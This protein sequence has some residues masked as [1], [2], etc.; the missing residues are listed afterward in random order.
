M[1]RYYKSGGK[2]CPKGKA[3]AN[4]PLTHIL[5]RMLI[6]LLLNTVKILTTQK[7]VRVRKR[8]R[9]NVKCKKKINC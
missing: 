6:W 5:A 9:N 3:W 4:E 2:I 1:R 7:V 8:R